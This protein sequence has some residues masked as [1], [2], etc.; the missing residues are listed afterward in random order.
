[1]T[2]ENEQ[3]TEQ[4]VKELAGLLAKNMVLKDDI[5]NPSEQGPVPEDYEVL[6]AIVEVPEDSTDRL[7]DLFEE[8]FCETRDQ[9][10][11]D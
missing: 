10:L 8:K 1:M 3:S 11:E 7:H 6:H 5:V 9:L 4:Q 2:T